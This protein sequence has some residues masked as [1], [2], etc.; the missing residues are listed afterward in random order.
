MKKYLKYSF[1][2]IITGLFLFGCHNSRPKDRLAPEEQARLIAKGKS[3]TMFSFKAFTKELT[4]ALNEGG[5]QH[6]VEYCN[7]RANP[8]TDSLSRAHNVRISRISE[9][10]RNPAD[11]PDQLDQTVLE[12]YLEQLAVGSKLQPHLEVTDH[13]VIFYSPILILDPIC[14]NCHGDPG[15]TMVQENYDFIKSKYPDDLA[16][17]YKLGDLRGAW[18]IVLSPEF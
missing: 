18:R 12:A 2:F 15:S 16:Y 7:L 17:G 8:L 1:C 10:Y 14:L 5:V 11:K 9:K 4:K 6:A 13:E 3:I